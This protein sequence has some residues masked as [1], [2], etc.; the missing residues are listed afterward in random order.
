MGLYSEYFEL[1][2]VVWSDYFAGRVS[3]AVRDARLAVLRSR[4]GI[5]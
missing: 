3:L 2:A 5:R 4:F 1:A